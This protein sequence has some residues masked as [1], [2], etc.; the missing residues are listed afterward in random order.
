MAKL[1]KEQILSVGPVFKEVNVPEWG[2]SV[3]IRP[4][5]L[6]EQARLADLG[7]KH[8]KGTVLARLRNCTLQLIQWV[9][10]DE[11]GQRLFEPGDLDALLDKGASAFL[12]LQDE[13][14]TTSGLTKDTREELEKNLPKAETAKPDSP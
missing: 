12:R 11:R 8:E 5:T 9:V 13:I 7:I 3:Y 14:L 1:T 4:I 6:G 2:G 10:C